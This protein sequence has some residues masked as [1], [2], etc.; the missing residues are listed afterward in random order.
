MIFAIAR[1]ILMGL[2]VLA[3]LYIL[4]SIYSRSVRAERLEARWED[5]GRPGARDVYVQQGLGDYDRSLR[6]KLILAVFIVPPVLVGVLIYA[7]NL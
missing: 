1:L 4:V 5:E 6:R 7:I 3:V 2:V